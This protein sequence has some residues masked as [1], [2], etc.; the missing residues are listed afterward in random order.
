MAKPFTFSMTNKTKYQSWHNFYMTLWFFLK[1]TSS[2]LVNCLFAVIVRSD[3]D[4][5]SFPCACNDWLWELKLYW[6]KP[7][8]HVIGNTSQNSF[9]LWFSH[10]VSNKIFLIAKDGAG[11]F[12]MSR[13]IFSKQISMCHLNKSHLN[14]QNYLHQVL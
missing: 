11:F 7:N 13:N 1:E 12:Q 3:P 6:K 4:L 14:S 9:I 2:L 8:Y 10:T 5:V